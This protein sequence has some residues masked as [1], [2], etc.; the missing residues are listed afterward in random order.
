MRANPEEQRKLHMASEALAIGAVAP[1]SAYIAATNPQ[2]PRWQRTFLY[3][4]AVGTLIVD[5]YLLGKWLE[6]K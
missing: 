2:L 5:G 4:L 3:G 6:K 1:V